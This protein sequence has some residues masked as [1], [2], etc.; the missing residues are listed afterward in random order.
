MKLLVASGSFKD[1]FSPFEAVDMLE[2]VFAEYG[3]EVDKCPFC[4]GGEYTYSILRSVL[5]NP[6]EIVVDDVSNAYGKRVASHYLVDDN[7]S[8]H[9][10]SSEIIR[11]YPEED[12]YKNP[13]NLTDYGYGQLIAD[14]IKK[15]FQDIKLYLGGTS[16]VDFG[17]GMLQALGGSIFDE[18]GW[19][20]PAPITLKELARVRRVSFDKSKY[21]LIKMTV[22]ADGDAKA[23]EMEGITRLK[24]G[25][26][27]AGESDKIIEA[28]NY[29]L[30]SISDV[31]GLGL[32]R[33]FSGAAGGMLYG[34]DSAFNANYLLGGEHFI[35]LLGLKEKMRRYDLVITG[36][37]RYDNTACGKAPASI[38]STAAAFGKPVLL[39]C[40]Q[41]VK[42]SFYDK[43]DYRGGIISAS[44]EAERIGISRI[45]TCQEY[46]DQYPAK[47]P[48]PEQTK[49]YK[50]MTPVILKKLIGKL[51]L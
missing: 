1:V 13:L 21:R 17:M 14:A 25:K 4:D 24:I 38:A 35:N 31:T 19:E 15:G 33:S 37:G 16:T 48:Y 51:D 18:T 2:K 3:Y 23:D 29:S 36:E 7:N 12:E 47:G 49:Y 9:I 27:F 42:N 45:I 6:K 34:I 44:G 20:F 30:Q 11:L 8:A 26:R 32:R 22:I 43:I 10:V 28:L 40:G 46:Y 39:V 5:K 50:E 41:I